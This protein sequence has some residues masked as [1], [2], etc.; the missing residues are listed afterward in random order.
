M[1]E[2]TRR[3]VLVIVVVCL[4]CPAVG[5]AASVTGVVKSAAKPIGSAPVALYRAG[6]S[7]TKAPVRLATARTKRDG[8]FSLSY[9]TQ[10]PSAVLYV[11]G[12]RLA[13]VLGD[14]RSVVVNE[15]TT[16]AAGFALGQFV[17]GDAI[18]GPAP[19]PVNA[20]AM[21]GNLVNPR[22]G[23][24]GRV[25]AAAPNGAQT[26]TLRAF[27]SLA[28]MAVPCARSANRCR[29]LFKLAQ[30][31]GGSAPKTLLEAV[32]DIAS[33]P[34]HNAA[35]LFKL[36]RGGPYR[37]ALASAPDAWILALRFYGDGKSLNGPGNMAID[38]QGNVWVTNNY[39][40]S[41]DPLAP[42]CGSNELF[43]FTP[44]GQYAPGSPFSGAGL[45][46][47]GFGIT[48]DPDGHIWVG[49]FGFSSVNCP[50]QPPHKSVSEFGPNGAQISP[51]ETATD[52]GGWETGGISWPQGTVADR[53]GRIWIANCGNDTVT[54][55][56][57][58]NPDDFNVTG[59]MGITKPFGIALNGIYAFVT[60]NGNNAVAMLSVDGRPTS[61]SPITGGGLNKPLGIASDSKGNL[62]VAN[63]EFV[64]VPCPDGSQSSPEGGS[65]TLIDRDG[66]PV[67]ATGFL[68][69]GLFNPWGVAVDGDDN[70]WVANFGGNRVSKF[71]G[72]AHKGCRAGEPLSPASGY[73]FDGLVRN[74]GVQID[75]SGNVWLANN[76]KTYPF[77]QANPG[78]YKLV[79]VVGA[80]APIKTPLI[81]PPEPV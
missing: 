47:A 37:P 34:S 32:A 38:A 78:G 48:I 69:G 67:G 39:E 68:G 4:V 40:Y 53:S 55:Y 74:T 76:W 63:S 52:D 21:G 9:K 46:G 57:L 43:E 58:G 56:R 22:T 31:R 3:V 16:V 64:D 79:A 36:A 73:T 29:A 12:G 61:R 14:S 51:A 80:A 7:R 19:G 30:P 28:N 62:W 1:N 70:V 54:Q 77:P 5:Q 8:S 44:S 65:L 35:A 23:G 66:K 72:T 11:I 41:R 45:N 25:L 59:G 18:A 42:V 13:T 49:N 24:A 60:G 17:K 6:S 27:N 15:R 26:S 75:P 10:K 81:G 71:C 33:D 50:S 2:V 20:A